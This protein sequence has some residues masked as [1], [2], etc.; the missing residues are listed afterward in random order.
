M[1]GKECRHARGSQLVS[2]RPREKGKHQDRVGG[3][4][5]NV[6]EMV[7]AGVKAEIVVSSINESQ[8]SGIQLL[9]WNASRLQVIFPG[10]SPPW[11]W[12]FALT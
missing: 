2:R 3:V 6:R 8:V 11:T 5:Q 10:V 7:R 9:S 1:Q 12:R 4:Q